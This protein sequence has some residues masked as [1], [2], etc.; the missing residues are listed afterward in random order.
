MSDNKESIRKEIE[1]KRGDRIPY[2]GLRPFTRQES[3][4]FFGREEHTKQLL[5][6]FS[7]ARFVSVTGLS[8]CGKTS[9]I[10]AGLLPAL[11]R[12]DAGVGNDWR[13][14]EMQLGNTP[15]LN[16]AEALLS[17][18]ALGR[19]AQAGVAEVVTFLQADSQN[20]TE[21]IREASLPRQT[22]F[23]LIVDQFEDL[24]REDNKE[25]QDNINAFIAL[26]LAGANQTEIPIYIVITLRSEFIGD[27]AQVQGLPEIMNT[28]QFLV[29][30]LTREQRERVVV[31]PAKACGGDV[32]ERLVNRLLDDLPLG[33]DQLPILQHCLR[34]LWLRAK[35]RI[36]EAR[37]KL[38][39]TTLEPSHPDG[40]SLTLEDYDAIGRIKNAFSNHFDEALNTLDQ[41]HQEIAKRLFRCFIVPQHSHQH[42]I[43]HP[44][45]VHKMAS[46]TNVPTIDVMQV[47]EV[48]RHPD[49]GLM[50]PVAE[51]SLNP[52]SAVNVSYESLLN[53]LRRLTELP[54]P[55][56]PKQPKERKPQKY[57]LF[58]IVII[59]VSIAVVFAFGE[60]FRTKK[61][62]EKLVIRDLELKNQINTVLGFS[63]TSKQ[64][65]EFL[66]WAQKV[67]A[68]ENVLNTLSLAIDTSESMDD[69]EKGYW[70][71][72]LSTLTEAEKSELLGGVRMGFAQ[73]M[74]SEET[75]RIYIKDATGAMIPAV[76]GIYYV[77]T[78]EKAT[79]GLSV[80]DR[81]LQNIIITYSA[82]RGTVQPDA[83]FTNATYT[84]P[85]APGIDSV[86]IRILDNKTGRLRNEVAVEFK[87]H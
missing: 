43:S 6:K 74:V 32:E 59:V 83:T 22:S 51:V 49:L 23:L 55:P 29:P 40:I 79:I 68:D 70:Q 76:G 73:K 57:S 48:F 2:P 5:E 46:L 39:P 26:L 84:A 36:D 38:A 50:T 54:A 47:I 35:S 75:F 28:N 63:P 37:K 66:E 18:S 31:E 19:E 33:P 77:E 85:N 58:P 69:Y 64:P 3:D 62:L 45:Q 30:G 10:Q 86:K 65:Q 56:Q 71:H 60:W 4:L 52:D 81:S 14:A 53:G 42:Y 27:C 12:G 87:V 44:V 41:E 11:E 78:Q 15:F 1:T 8:G 25:N 16:L 20:L 24:F 61:E 80:E 34:R 72:A 21:G 7:D 9:L 13:V 82:E 67:Y 17:D